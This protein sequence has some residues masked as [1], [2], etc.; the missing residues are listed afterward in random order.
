[1][2]PRDW[3]QLRRQ[4]GL[5]NGPEESTTTEALAE[6]DDHKDYSKENRGVGRGYTTRPRDWRQQQRQQRLDDS[7]G[8]LTTTTEFY[9]P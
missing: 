9:F 3:R 5:A 7:T 1:M 4:Q 6:E 2:R 8:G